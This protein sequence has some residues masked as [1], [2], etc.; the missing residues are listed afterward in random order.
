[1][2]FP[3]KTIIVLAVLLGI[4]VGGYLFVPP[5]LKSIYKT[6]FRTVEISEG[7]VVT[8]V[9]ATG[10][11]NPELSVN[12]GS[13]VS[14][15]IIE[16]KADFNDEVKK[17]Q[18]LAKIDPRLYEANYK[19]D[20]AQLQTREAEVKRV[21]ALRDLAE[22]D[23]K[24]AMNLKKVNE[25]YISQGELDQFHYNLESLK[26]QYDL[27]VAAVVQA[28]ANLDNSKTNLD[29]TSILA[30]VDGIII[31]RKIDEG[32]TLASQFQTPELFIIA[33]N[34]REKM[35]I[36]ANVDEADIG[37]INYAKQK[38]LP[39][40]FTV[41]AY[42]EELFE[43][44]IFQIRMSSTTT[45]NVVTYPV[46][47]TTTNPDL[48]LKPGMTANISFEVDSVKNAKRIPNSA[49]RYYPDRNLVHPDDHKI[50]DGTATDK[51]D[52]ES[53]EKLSATQTAELRRKR[54]RRHVWIQ[55]GDKLRAIEVIT[56]I[57]DNQYTVLVEGPLEVGK[58]LVIGI[59]KSR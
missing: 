43:G 41:D 44:K 7:D 6:K 36:E 48:K 47:V 35:H 30:P 4:G 17:G 5:Y 54:N 39:V 26:A 31:D 55:E 33:P 3:I 25:E 9:N 40:T 11:L 20:K 1:M 21:V 59:E 27:A 34:M 8:I 24:R 23:L 12:V 56:G 58:K 2:K 13:F 32:Q 50:L 14:G 15:P 46:I 19:R 51:N 53:Q 45:Q 57:S 28:E 49:L 29:Y 52:D 38:N 10:T 18:L 42:P 37:L 22:R 16:L